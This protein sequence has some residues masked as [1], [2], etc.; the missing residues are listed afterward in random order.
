MQIESI[1]INEADLNQGY[2]INDY[3]LELTGGSKLYNTLNDL[4]D[5]PKDPHQN[6]GE[7]E[8]LSRIDTLVQDHEDEEMRQ[9]INDQSKNY[10]WVKV[11]G[12]GTF[13]TVFH[14][15]C[16]KSSQPV[17][18]KKVYQDPKYRNREFSIVVELDHPNCIKVHNYFFTQG[19]ENPD[20]IYLNIVMDYIPDTLYRLLRYY[21]KSNQEFPNMLAKLLC[22]QLLRSMAYIKGLQI[23]HRDIK[24]Q[25]ILIDSQSYRL[26]LC[27]FGS[28]KKLE[29]GEESIAYICSR[30]YRSPEL[31]LGVK[32]YGCEVDMWAAGCVFAEM[33]LGDPLFLGNNNKEQFLRILS[34]MGAPT[35]SDYESMDYPHEVKMPKLEPITLERKLGGKVD[36]MAI[37]LMKRL[38]CYN[39]WERLDPFEGLTHPYFDDLR[40][41]KVRVNGREVVDLFDFTPEEVAGRQRLLKKLVPEWYEGARRRGLGQDGRSAEMQMEPELGM[42]FET[43]KGHAFEDRYFGEDGEEEHPTSAMFG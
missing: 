42:G 16:L 39:R 25:N 10:N 33:F 37:D 28:A 19:E 38:L 18:I 20:E 15:Y 32:D 27:D 5:P 26:A 1:N 8:D 31:I 11:I 40:R 34:I 22:Y 29:P 7:D 2:N 17:A 23:C 43:G 12:Q 21:K 9:A 13:G 35:K 30:Y 36:P 4:D 24:P 14:A 6:P 41:G 3:Q